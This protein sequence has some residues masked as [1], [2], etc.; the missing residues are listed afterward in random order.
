MARVEKLR[1]KKQVRIRQDFNFG[2]EAQ[3]ITPRKKSGHRVIGSSDEVRAAA[4]A[5]PDA[6]FADVTRIHPNG[7]EK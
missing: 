4:R 5:K 7:F 1:R 2:M 6:D 3:R